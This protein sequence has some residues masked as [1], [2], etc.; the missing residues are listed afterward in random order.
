MWL[1]SSMELLLS[2]S[3]CRMLAGGMMPCLTAPMLL[4]E[5]SFMIR[6]SL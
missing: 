3:L 5:R 6:S 2:F 4:L 1:E